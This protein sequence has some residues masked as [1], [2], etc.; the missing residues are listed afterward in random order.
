MRGGSSGGSRA[1]EGS[2]AAGPKMLC[3]ILGFWKTLLLF[4]A[5]A[6]YAVKIGSYS[7]IVTYISRRFRG[8]TSLS[9]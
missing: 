7:W 2:P 8:K 9:F 4:P 5:L 6:S 1:A 3:M